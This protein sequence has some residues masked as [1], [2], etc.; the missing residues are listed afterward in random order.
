MG[1]HRA[2]VHVDRGRAEGIRHL[3][4]ELASRLD[5]FAVEQHVF[6]DA[7]Q[8]IIVEP[9]V[10][11]MERFV[12]DQ[13]DYQVNLDLF[14]KSDLD[15]RGEDAEIRFRKSL[16]DGAMDFRRASSSKAGWN[17]MPAASRAR[18]DKL[19]AW[20]PCL[21]LGNRPLLSPVPGVNVNVLVKQ[22]MIVIGK[23][24]RRTEVKAT[25]MSRIARQR[26][27]EGKLR[28]DFFATLVPH[29]SRTKVGTCT[30]PGLSDSTT[31]FNSDDSMVSD[32]SLSH[33]T[34]E[35]EAMST[36]TID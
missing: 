16:A 27:K 29:A 17:T 2:R 28:V 19:C 22:K 34:E 4:F 13:Y 30:E 6:L 21:S 5:V 25:F 8:S 20:T 26:R 23:N 11:L 7:L 32:S 10:H 1:N 35:A 15:R 33:E 3:T 36:D 18:V 12:R 9:A 31:N 14:T 24:S